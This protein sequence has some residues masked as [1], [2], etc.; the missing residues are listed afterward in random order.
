MRCLTMKLAN[1]TRS[2]KSFLPSLL[3]LG[4][5][6]PASA[7]N[8]AIMEGVPASAATVYVSTTNRRV[9]IATTS[10]NGSIP[11]VALYT[12]SNVAVST[13]GNAPGIVLYASGTVN[14]PY[15]SGTHLGNGS[16]LTGMTQSQISGLTSRFDGVAQDTTTIGQNLASTASALTIEISRA[17]QRENGIGNSTGT[18]YSALNATG[19]A[20][21]SEINRSVSRE[22]AIAND[23]GTLTGY[24]NSTGSALTS[25]ISRAI[26]RENVIGTATGTIRSDF[27]TSTGTLLGYINSTGSALTSETNRAVARENAIGN[28]T[29]TTYSELNSTASAL[30]VLT[31]NVA[32]GVGV[33]IT[34]G[35]V[36]NGTNGAYQFVTLDSLGSI[37]SLDGGNLYNV[38]SAPADSLLFYFDKTDASDISNYKVLLTSPSP[39]VESS[40]AVLVNANNVDFSLGSFATQSN[41]PAVTFIPA[42]VWELECWNSASVNNSSVIRLDVYIRHAAGNEV[43][44]FASTGATITNATVG[45]QEVLFV[46]NTSTYILTT[47]RV[48][49]KLNARKTGGANSTVT[50]YFEGT[51]HASH[52]H[53]PLGAVNAAGTANQ[54]AKFTSAQVLGNSSISDDGTSVSVNAAEIVTGQEIVQGSSTVNGKGRFGDTLTVIN[55]SDAIYFVNNAVRIG[56]QTVFGTDHY[57][58]LHGYTG[59]ALF[60]DG[61]SLTNPDLV[62]EAGVTRFRPNTLYTSTMTSVGGLQLPNILTI[63]GANGEGINLNRGTGS[64]YI[65]WQDGAGSSDWVAYRSD[66]TNFRFYSV[67][68]TGHRWNVSNAYNGGDALTVDTD[69]L[70]VGINDHDPSEALGVNGTGR[71][72]G[73]IVAVTG[74]FSGGLT[75]SSGTFTATGNNQYSL[76]ASSGMSMAHGVLNLGDGC[77]QFSGG[78]QCLPFSAGSIGGSGTIGQIPV[79]TAASAI[80]DSYISQTSTGVT[81]S[82]NTKVSGILSVEQAYSS[83]TVIYATAGRSVFTVP[84]GVTGIYVKAWGGGGGQG[85]FSATYPAGNGAG[86]HFAAGRIPVTPG[87]ILVVFSGGA[88]GPGIGKSSGTGGIGLSTTTGGWGGDGGVSSTTNLSQLVG[89]GGG[90]GGGASGVYR[91]G[92]SS[93]SLVVAAGGGGGG[94]GGDNAVNPQA[95]GWNSNACD[96]CLATSTGGA[97]VSYFGPNTHQGGGGGGSG[98]CTAGGAGGLPDGNFITAYGGG[99]GDSCGP[100]VIPSVGISAANNSDPSYNSYGVGGTQNSSNY[101]SSGAVIISYSPNIINVTNSSNTSFKVQNNGY[102]GILTPAPQYPLDVNGDANITGNLIA[103][104]ATFGNNP[105]WISSGTFMRVSSVTIN[106]NSYGL[107]VASRSWRVDYICSSTGNASW[108]AVNINSDIGPNYHYAAAGFSTTANAI[109]A[110]GGDADRSFDLNGHLTSTGGGSISG[111]AYFSTCFS[112]PSSCVAF[113]AMSQNSR[114][115]G[116]ET[117]SYSAGKY[118]GTSDLSQIQFFSSSVGSGTNPQD[119]KNPISCHY[120]VWPGDTW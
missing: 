57:L 33:G 34:T 4:F 20:L 1:L 82:T 108:F 35:N 91:V 120:T 44:L 75:A 61:T 109:G 27:A 43:L 13:G 64:S 79:F 96:G 23:T 76:Q 99:N 49:A 116:L 25:E 50:M 30:T 100:V 113:R 115:S 22:N 21:T 89:G 28:S 10:Y 110:Q 5:A 94:G 101:S 40:S 81:V 70:R 16:N 103:N 12:T 59:T 48:I 80:G 38:H 54:I 107:S 2:Y 114:S 42:G 15:L 73:G 88:G 29:G 86:G 36:L 11:N 90:G 14:A 72:T 58:G 24:V 31:N 60:S 74:T 71:F 45:V 7:Q 6:I 32:V 63:G 117:G 66:S 102:V 105:G 98:G 87:E 118:T 47:D 56:R 17:I 93:V 8:R 95:D 77:L 119:F 51:A 52:L 39:N 97:G 106:L 68:D 26:S 9:T 69:H 62:T 41:I 46:T 84:V 18:T 112:Q 83:S 55:G 53:T 92:I 78:T 3:A 37:P 85:A 111:S 67:T 65:N 19:S 104:T